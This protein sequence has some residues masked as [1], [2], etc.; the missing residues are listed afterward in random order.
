MIHGPIYLYTLHQQIRSIQMF[1]TDVLYVRVIN[2]HP[3]G[4]D[5]IL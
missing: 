4:F 5:R 2:M 1:A 3:L